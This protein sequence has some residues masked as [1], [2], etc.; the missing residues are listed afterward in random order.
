[1]SGVLIGISASLH[2]FG[3][4]GAG[5]QRPAQRRAAQLRGRRFSVS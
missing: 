1:M 5:I 3:D 4:P 2:D